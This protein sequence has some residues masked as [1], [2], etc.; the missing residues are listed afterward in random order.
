MLSRAMGGYCPVT[1]RQTGAWVR[2][3]LRLP[4]RVRQS[5][6]SDGGPGEHDAARAGSGTLLPALGGDCAV[7]LV[8]EGKQVRGSIFHAAGVSRSA[9]FCSPTPS[10][11]RRS[12]PIRRT[13]ASVDVAADGAIAS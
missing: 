6:V 10:A 13:Y 1:I 7:S 12:R 2:R 9:V 5:R 3:T 8:D 11:R 4:R